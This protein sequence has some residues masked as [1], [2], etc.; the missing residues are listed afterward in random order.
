MK[1]LPIGR[2]QSAGRCGAEAG[3]AELAV[4]A[5]AGGGLPAG[6]RGLSPRGTVSSRA[7]V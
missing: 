1:P 3:F 7:R 6:R 2:R 5:V 4:T